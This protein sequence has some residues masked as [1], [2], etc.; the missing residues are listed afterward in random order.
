VGQSRSGPRALAGLSAVGRHL[1]VN[2]QTLN[3][4][5]LACLRE[6]MPI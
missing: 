4:G 1:S 6:R 2:T 5:G 3:H